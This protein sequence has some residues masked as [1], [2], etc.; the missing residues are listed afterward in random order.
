MTLDEFK[1]SLSDP[2]APKLSL[3]LQA[4]WHDGKGDWTQAHDLVNDLTD[5]DSAYVHAYLHR[6][7]GDEWNASYWYKNAGKPKPSKSLDAEWEDLVS[8]FL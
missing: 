1:A 6:K 3:A 7:E 4:L 8:Y 2:K 5:K